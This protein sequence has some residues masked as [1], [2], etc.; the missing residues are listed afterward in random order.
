[1][2]HAD[3]S[4]DN[5]DTTAAASGANDVDDQKYRDL[6]LRGGARGRGEGTTGGSSASGDCGP[7]SAGVVV[8]VA[9]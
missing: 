3:E 5:I 4:K 1:M 2:F 9:E 6:R 8:L 7:R